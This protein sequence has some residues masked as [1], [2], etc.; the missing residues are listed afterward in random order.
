MPHQ[1]VVHVAEQQRILRRDQRE[2]AAA[3]PQQHLALLGR[4]APQLEDVALD[5]QQRRDVGVA[6][7]REHRVLELLDARLDVVEHRLEPVNL[8]VEDGVQHRRRPL[9]QRDA[10]PRHLLHHRRD[11]ART[12]PVVGDEEVRAQEGIQLHRVGDVGG[13]AR[14]QAVGDHVEVSPVLVDLRLGAGAEAVLDR[15]RMELEHV[16]QDRD[17]GVADGRR[18]IDP[19]PG[20]GPRRAAPATPRARAR[21]RRALRERRRESETRRQGSRPGGTSNRRRDGRRRSD[22]A[23]PLEQPLDGRGKLP[24]R[25]ADE[26]RAAPVLVVD[27]GGGAAQDSNS[28]R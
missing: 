19:D 25:A 12:R 10:G 22:Y 21:A 1:V 16:T 6:R 18:E 15:Q 14:R 23:R 24:G 20:L 3:E 4:P 9:L 7:P 27:D 26:A 5:R 13:G 2:L 28:A 17:L 8:T 11:A